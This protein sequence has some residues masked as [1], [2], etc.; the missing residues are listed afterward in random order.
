M[1]EKEWAE[2]D[3]VEGLGETEKALKV[4]INGNEEWVP[5]SQIAKDSEVTGEGDF[6]TLKV[7]RWLAEKRG[8]L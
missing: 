3:D 8:W 6:G 1:A 2:L 7:S 5:R 4:D